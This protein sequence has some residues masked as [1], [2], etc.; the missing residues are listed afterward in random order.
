MLS[1]TARDGAHVPADAGVHGR[2]ANGLYFTL[3]ES[4]IYSDETSGLAFSPD[5]KQ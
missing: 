4:P 1:L 5:G 3:L 2:D